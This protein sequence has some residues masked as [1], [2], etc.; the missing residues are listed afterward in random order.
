MVRL[1]ERSRACIVTR[2]RTLSGMLS[3][4]WGHIIRRVQMPPTTKLI[5]LM[6]ASYSDGDTGE[7][8]R[9]GHARLAAVSCV[10]VSTVERSIKALREMGLI[11]ELS[12]G[13]SRGR[14]GGGLAAVY[15][16]TLP[17]DL[18][19]SAE[20]LDVDEKRAAVAQSASSDPSPVQ[21]SSLNDP[22]PVPG[23]SANDLAPV[24]DDWVLNHPLNDPESSVIWAESSVKWPESPVMGDDPPTH[25]TPTHSTPTQNSPKATVTS[26]R[27]VESRDSTARN[28]MQIDSLILCR[29]E[30]KQLTQEQERQRQMRALEAMMNTQMGDA[31]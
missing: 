18:L 22:S 9:P 26:A 8:I 24:L 25:L 31:S 13:R 14:N 11:E 3:F 6:L 21:D 20:M 4:E 1:C 10:S 30:S 2:A 7:N 12:P 16:L 23:D 28:G 27:D 15:R 29:D 5:A 17:D 19:G